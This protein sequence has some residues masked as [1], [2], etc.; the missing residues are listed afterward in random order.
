[1]TD[2]WTNVIIKGNIEPVVMARARAV[3]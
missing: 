3:R 2:S 1:L